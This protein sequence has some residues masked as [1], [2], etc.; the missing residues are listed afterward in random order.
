MKAVVAR[1]YGGPEVLAVEEIPVPRPGPGQFQVRIRAAGLNPADLRTLSGVLHRLTPLEFPYVLGSD[2]AG[3]VTEVGP[4]VARFAVGEEVFG[5]GLPRATGEMATMLSTPPSLTTGT[6]AE[7]AVFEADTPAIARRPENLD[8]EQAATLPIAGLTALSLLRAG[9]FDPADGQTPLTS[10]GRALVTGAAG[11]VGGVVVPLLVAAGLEVIATA[12]PDDEQ[13]VRD[14]GAADVIDYRSV[15]T[16]TE[17]L[18]RHPR[19]IDTLIN[20]ALPGPAL[21]EASRV[22][23][24][25]GQLLNAAFPS[26]DPSAFDGADLTVKTAYSTARPGDLGRLAAYA[27]DG[28]L[29]STISRRYALT[30]APRAYADLVHTHVRGKLLVTVAPTA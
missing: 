8:A 2:F 26:P 20:L 15:D 6:M 23:R 14:L 17:T 24:P 30:Q 9:G 29:T 22:L 11:G 16:I 25:G 10:G 28:T 18:R 7:Y 3:T 5:V 1:E 27:L 12:I 4:D 13:Y 19:G 21:I